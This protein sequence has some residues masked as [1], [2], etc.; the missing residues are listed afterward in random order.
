VL[1]CDAPMLRI[2]LTLRAL[3][4][5]PLLAATLDHGRTLIACGPSQSCLQVAGESAFGAFGAATLVLY[6]AGLGFLL[7]RGVRRFPGGGRMRLWLLATATLAAACAGQALL[8]GAAGHGALGGGWA[9]MAPL[10]LLA[11]TALALALRVVP[12]A[13][14]LARSLRP[15]APRLGSLAGAL[16]WAPAARGA[17]PLPV[18]A[19][20]AAGRAPP[21]SL[22]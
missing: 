5:V 17:H 13:V 4:L 15:R 11:G 22:G 8:A 3:L 12:A 16:T 14:A 2:P 9:Q 19:L 18:L 20:A 21:S 1:N 10:V 6:A 7:A